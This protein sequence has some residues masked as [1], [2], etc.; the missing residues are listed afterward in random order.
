MID[1]IVVTLVRVARDASQ[2]A[3]VAAGRA[4]QRRRGAI[5]DPRLLRADARQPAVRGRRPA[6]RR[7][8]AAARAD[9]GGARSRCCGSSR[10]SSRRGSAGPSRCGGPSSRPPTI[11]CSASSR[12]RR[13]ATST[14]SS[15]ARIT[16]CR[17]TTVRRRQTR[18]SPTARRPP[19]SAW[20]CWRR[21]PRTISAS[22]DAGTRRADRPHADDDGRAS[23]RFEGHL[24]NW[25][26]TP[27]PRA[28]V[29]A[30]RVVGGQR[31]PGVGALDARGGT[32]RTRTRACRRS[33]TSWGSRK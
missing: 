30:L 11:S 12:G 19:T 8:L 3:R 9:G 25:Y 22:F 2:D 31:K 29:T 13:G 16:F 4:S 18:S 15:A 17:P 20:A 32:A 27:E 24:F 23:T 26:D 6:H 21:S 1:A 5:H 7:D 14:R 33:P 10:R 28:A